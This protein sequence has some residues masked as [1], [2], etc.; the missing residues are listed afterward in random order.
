M[1]GRSDTSPCSQ[2]AAQ[3][4]FAAQHYCKYI[5]PL[6]CKT[7]VPWCMR[8]TYSL[9]SQVESHLALPG[10]DN[11]DTTLPHINFHRFCKYDAV[12]Y[13]YSATHETS[14]YC[15]IEQSSEAKREE[16]AEEGANR[17]DKKIQPYESHYTLE[18]RNYSSIHHC[19]QEFCPPFLLELRYST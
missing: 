6:I 9:S 17:G 2:G 1:A 15:I 12:P 3:P 16:A 7:L 11:P 5:S 14:Y 18:S 8:T 19:R 4:N 10:L 13:R